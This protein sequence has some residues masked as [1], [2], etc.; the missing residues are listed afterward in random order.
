MLR[1]NERES[2]KRREDLIDAFTLA[3]KENGYFFFWKTKIGD[4]WK[5]GITK[6]DSVPR[7]SG[8]ILPYTYFWVH[9]LCFKLGKKACLAVF[10]GAMRY[11]MATLHPDTKPYMFMVYN[12]HRERACYTLSGFIR[13]KKGVIF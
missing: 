11:G 13:S 4:A 12:E 7:G 1:V 8:Y 5:A 9:L 6:V 10:A 3:A 2:L